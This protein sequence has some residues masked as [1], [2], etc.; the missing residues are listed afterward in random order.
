[1][2][3]SPQRRGACRERQVEVKVEVILVQG[4]HFLFYTLFLSPGS[5]L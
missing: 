2:D 3:I 4:E 5:G 1:M